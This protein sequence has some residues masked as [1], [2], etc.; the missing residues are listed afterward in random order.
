M[1]NRPFQAATG[2]AVCRTPQGLPDS[3]GF[4]PIIIPRTRAVQI[5]LVQ[6]IWPCISSAEN[7]G[8]QMRQASGIG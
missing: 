7:I 1:P 8:N 6:F 3:Q 4:I 5:D 2:N